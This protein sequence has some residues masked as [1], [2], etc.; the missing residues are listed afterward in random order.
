M[1]GIRSYKEVTI[2]EGVGTKMIL[3][4]VT[5]GVEMRI[6]QRGRVLQPVDVESFNT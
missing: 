6:N 4:T 5:N 1:K 2:D 3:C